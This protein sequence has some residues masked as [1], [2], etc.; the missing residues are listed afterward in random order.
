M[1]TIFT[2]FVCRLPAQDLAA[3]DVGVHRIGGHKAESWVEVIIRWGGASKASKHGP[4]G[5]KSEP[6]WGG[7]QEAGDLH[8][9]GGGVHWVAPVREADVGDG[10]QG[11]GHRCVRGQDPAPAA[12][13]A[14]VERSHWVPQDQHQEW[15]Q[16]RG[17]HQ[18]FRLGMDWFA[19]FHLLP[20]VGC[21]WGRLGCCFFFL[22]GGWFESSGKRVTG[23]GRAL[24]EL[25]WTPWMRLRGTVVQLYRM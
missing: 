23:T 6:W 15:L 19:F 10:A 9:R 21:R 17:P 7:D 12:A 14:G 4:Q 8:D 16:A 1:L 5:G 25:L 24:L 20:L 3:P 13:G 11:A 22:G 18:S 2:R